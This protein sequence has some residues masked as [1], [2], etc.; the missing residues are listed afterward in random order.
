[1]DGQNNLGLLAQTAANNTPRETSRWDSYEGPE[2]Q[3]ARGSLEDIDGALQRTRM[4][5]EWVLP[6]L[7]T[8]LMNDPKRTLL[9]NLLQRLRVRENYL[10]DLYELEE[11]A[12]LKREGNNDLMIAAI[13]GEGDTLFTLLNQAHQKGTHQLIL[14]HRNNENDNVLSLLFKH[15]HRDILVM[16]FD[17]PIKHNPALTAFM[18]YAI[19]KSHLW[20]DAVLETKSEYLLSPLLMA[21]SDLEKKCLFTPDH[22]QQY[23]Y[24]ARY[25]LDNAPV[26][27][28]KGEN[29][30]LAHVKSIP[31]A[32]RK[33]HRVKNPAP[34]RAAKREEGGN[35]RQQMNPEASSNS[36]NTLLQ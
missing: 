27:E 28:K 35:K 36:N 15:K 7:S 25:L 13:L 22:I 12:R 21:N 9:A 18:S 11:R 4:S 3:N 10:M 2:P 1:M 8:L 20:I 14:S 33:P 30:L 23:P 29:D 32:T 31:R 6:S 19:D 26:L 5:I 34:K 24:L 17:T 16:L